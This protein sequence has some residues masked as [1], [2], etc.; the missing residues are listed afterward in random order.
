MIFLIIINHFLFS[1]KRF[2]LSSSDEM[3]EWVVAF[4]NSLYSDSHVQ[5]IKSNPDIQTLSNNIALNNAYNVIN[6]NNT[7]NPTLSHIDELSYGLLMGMA[8]TANF[9]TGLATGAV[10]AGI[11]LAA[12]QLTSGDLSNFFTDQN[13]LLDQLNPTRRMNPYLGSYLNDDSTVY[14]I[15]DGLFSGFSDSGG[16]NANTDAVPIAEIGLLAFLH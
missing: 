2:S 7:L 5:N 15:G 10:G 12:N 9:N 14:Y 11:G 16:G 4:Q 13:G 1:N 3:I 6:L 8:N